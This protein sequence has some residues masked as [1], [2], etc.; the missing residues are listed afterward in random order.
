LTNRSVKKTRVSPRTTKQLEKVREKSR[1]KIVNA[2]I[3]L[4]AKKGYH[5]TSI[6]GIAAKAG[7]AKGLM[8]HYFKSKSELLDEILKSSMTEADEPMQAL[9]LPGEP[10]DKLA[11]MIEGTFAMVEQDKKRWQLLVSIMTQYEVLGRVKKT[12]AQ[13]M[14]AYMG[15]FEALFAEMKVPQPKMEAYRLAALLDGVMLHYIYYMPENYPLE[16]IKNQII[17]EYA[18][19]RKKK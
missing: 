16:E 15:I 9:M 1:T 14:Q 13:M 5:S 4:F 6:S 19:Y 2:A 18:K 10:V 3:E 17:K 7:I 11:M 12:F 8:Y